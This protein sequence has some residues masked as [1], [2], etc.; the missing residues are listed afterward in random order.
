VGDDIADAGAAGAGGAGA[1][2][3]IA[4]GIVAASAG[5]GA[6]ALVGG[7]VRAFAV[8]AAVVGVGT[9]RIR[10]GGPPRLRGVVM[11]T[12]GT[13]PPATAAVDAAMAAGW[14]T[15]PLS[16]SS[17]DAFDDAGCVGGCGCGANEIGRWGGSADTSKDDG[18]TSDNDD[19]SADEDAARDRFGFGAAVLFFFLTKLPGSDLGVVLLLLLAKLRGKGGAWSW[20][21]REGGGGAPVSRVRT[22][23]ASNGVPP[24]SD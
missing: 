23:A 3:G 13:R 22:R 10:P 20:A 19:D 6:D 8:F 21:G 4:A 18:C 14:R 2:G 7:V 24:S 11:V 16:S 9:F 1:A 12:D 17:G 15:A 5:A